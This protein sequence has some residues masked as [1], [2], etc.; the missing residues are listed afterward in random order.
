M[1]TRRVVSQTLL[2]QSA[3]ARHSTQVGVVGCVQHAGSTA[4]Q[5]WSTPPGP[6]V[7]RQVTQVLVAVSQTSPLRQS[8]VVVHSTQMSSRHTGSPAGQPALGELPSGRHGTH[9]SSSQMGASPSQPTSTPPP[10]IESRHST[11]V[12]VVVSHK[13]LGQSLLPWHSRT[14]SV[15]V[16]VEHTRTSFAGRSSQART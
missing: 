14:S 2:G 5:P 4:A 13:P 1:H 12:S 15:I 3:S 16:V 6:A 8:F 11:Q 10:P 9:T 7:S